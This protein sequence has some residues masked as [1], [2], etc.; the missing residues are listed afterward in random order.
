MTPRDSVQGVRPSLDAADLVAAVPQLADVAE[1]S[2]RTLCAVPSASLTVPDMLAAAEAARD[3]VAR[4]AAG[5]VITQGTDTLEETAFLLDLVWDRPEPLVA[6]GAM[7]SPNQ[8]SA[9]GPGN[10]LAAVTA[11]ASTACRD[12]GCLVV[13]NDNIHAARYVQKR[14]ASSL[15][16]F[17]SPDGGPLG[18]VIEGRVRLNVSAPPKPQVRCEATA[19]N[20]RVALVEATFDDDGELISHCAEAGYDGIVV[21]AL[22]VGHLSQQAAARAAAAAAKAPVVLASRTGAGGV[23]EGTYG[24]VGSETDLLRAGLVSAGLLT[25]RKARVLLLMLL[26][27]GADQ[28]VIRSAFAAFGGANGQAPEIATARIPAD[29]RGAR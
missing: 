18:A 21:S 10:V 29:A 20:V 4:G 24:F 7:R 2:A 27:S 22:G 14:H 15:Q 19:S 16:A 13:M 5:V 9:D 8:A 17:V 6:T 3:E 12:L 28:A 25:P 11:A 26:R 1:V 23:F